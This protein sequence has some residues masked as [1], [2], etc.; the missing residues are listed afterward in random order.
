VRAIAPSFVTSFAAAWRVV[1]FG[2]TWHSSPEFGRGKW[3]HGSPEVLTE[4]AVG[5]TIT[6]FA[7]L[8]RAFSHKPARLEISDNG[9]IAH[10][11]VVP[12][13]LYRVEGVDQTAIVQHP[14]SAMCRA[15][16]WITTR[17]LALTPIP[18]RPSEGD[19]MRATDPLP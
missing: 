17:P 2:E 8:A 6:P 3:Y 11:G 9:A 12:G 14:R 16:E 15:A 4:L 1:S 19:A 5:S 7:D 13:L 18:F 10:N